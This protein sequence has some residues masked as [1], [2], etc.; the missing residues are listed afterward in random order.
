MKCVF[1]FFKSCFCLP[2]L[3]LTFLLIP[4]VKFLGVIVLFH[5][6]TCSPN[7]RHGIFTACTISVVGIVTSYELD[8]RRFGVQ[9]P[10]GSRIFSSPLRP[11]WLWGPPN[12]LSNGY[13]GIFPWV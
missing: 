11:D 13:W 4:V 12:F 9:V 5:I 6:P 2:F 10:V 8:N 3:S 1:T 7:H